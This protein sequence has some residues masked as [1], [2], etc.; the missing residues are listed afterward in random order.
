MPDVNTNKEP[1]LSPFKV[2]PVFLEKIWGGQALG[3]KLNKKI[4]QNIKIGE[5]WEISG[6]EPYQSTITDGPHKGKR[7]TDI[8]KIY[9]SKFLGGSFRNDGFPL[10]CKFID[11]NDILSVQVHPDDS[12]AVELRLGTRGKTECW[13]IVDAA[14]GATIIVGLRKSISKEE[15]RIAI[16]KGTFREMLKEEPIA[17][18]DFLFIPAGTIHAIMSNTLIYEV[19]ESSDI[20]LRVYDWDRI[21]ISDKPRQLHIEDAVKVTDTLAHE[22]YKIKPVVLT[23]KEYTH[24]YRVACRYFLIEQYSTSTPTTIYL[25]VK[26]SFTILTMMKGSVVLIDSSKKAIT[27]TNGESILIPAMWK[28]CSISTSAGSEILLSSVP[29]LMSEVIVPLKK[30]DVAV[31]DIIAL[32]GVVE[33]RNDILKEMRG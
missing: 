33:E 9:G 16:N 2:S 28:D 5:S 29:D 10:L 31:K 25:P 12:Q 3:E 1:E 24:S 30:R 19:Q 18:G 26:I 27:V 21:D 4:P 17:P 11:A 23:Y 22:S 13:Y 20:T 8:C 14:P 15:M 7:L 6:E 32:G